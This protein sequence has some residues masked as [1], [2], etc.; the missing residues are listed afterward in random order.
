MTADPGARR[1]SPPGV[2]YALGKHAGTSLLSRPA[3]LMCS[4]EFFDVQY[5]INP[6]MEGNVHAPSGRLACEQWNRLHAAVTEHAEVLL[7]DPQSA[8]PNMVFTANAG[9][10]RNGI[11]VLS[12]FRCPERA[13]EEAHF[14]AWFRQAGYSV[15]EMPPNVPFEGE[16][17]A[18]FT[19]DG[20]C[21]WAGYG[22]RTGAA[23]CRD[24]GRRGPLRLQCG[25]CWRADRAER[26]QSGSAKHA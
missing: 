19:P 23:A 2:F 8:L 22:W 3:F 17:D 14:E 26:D 11:A 25:D 24:R 7:V 10:I 12:R 20:A 13:G 6:W 1:H 15:R 9:L 21:L 16:G 5:V 18:L 4:P